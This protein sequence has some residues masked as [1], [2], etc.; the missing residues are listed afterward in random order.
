MLCENEACDLGLADESATAGRLGMKFISCPVPDRSLP[1]DIIRFREIVSRLVVH[2]RRGRTVGVH[3]RA[4]IG[5]STVLLAALMVALG[6]E[7]RQALHQIEL[8]REY[9]VPDTP[10]Q[11]AWI[12]QFRASA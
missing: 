11:R 1:E 2:V 12:L 8:A 3:C 7:A 6:T 9:P 10:E 5:R 4:C